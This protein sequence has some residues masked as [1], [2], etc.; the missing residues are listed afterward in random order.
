MGVSKLQ[1]SFFVNLSL[2][3]E[4]ISESQSS[5]AGSEPPRVHSVKSVA[6]FEEVNSKRH[7]EVVKQKIHWKL[8]HWFIRRVVNWE[9]SRDRP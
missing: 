9:D 4:E 5:G 8:E 7:E 3:K 6:W 2:A 1:A